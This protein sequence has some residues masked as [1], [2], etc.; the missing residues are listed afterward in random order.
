[1][2]VGFDG[3]GRLLEMVAVLGPDGIWLVYHA[4]TSPSKKTLKELGL[5]DERE[6]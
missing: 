4:M 3:K 5:K 1:V 2:A 6:R